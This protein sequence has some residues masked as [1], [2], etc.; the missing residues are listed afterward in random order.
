MI[1]REQLQLIESL[2]YRLLNVLKSK[3]EDYATEDVL[4][5]FKQVSSAAKVLN[6]DVGNPTN[7]AL[8]MCVLKIARLT[9]LINNNKVPNNESIDDS[10]IDLIGYSKLAYCNYKDENK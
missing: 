6:I 2:D 9:N 4:S 7:Y 3:G 8:F 1:K 5:N 10:F